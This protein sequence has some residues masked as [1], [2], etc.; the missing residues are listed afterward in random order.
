MIFER[1]NNR[2]STKVNITS[3][4]DLKGQCNEIWTPHTYEQV[5]TVRELFRFEKQADNSCLKKNVGICKQKVHKSVHSILLIEPGVNLVGSLAPFHHGNCPSPPVYSR[6]YFKKKK[7]YFSFGRNLISCK[8]CKGSNMSRKGLH[9]G[10]QFTYIVVHC[11][12][13]ALHCSYRYLVFNSIY[14]AL[15]CS[16]HYL[17]LHCIYVA[18]HCSVALW[19]FLLQNL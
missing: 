14:V 1:N 16:K 4:I 3:G 15:H 7:K 11:I 10:N 6:T 2:C 13:V 5:K 8:I 12:Y 18:L 17:V 9:W 19:F